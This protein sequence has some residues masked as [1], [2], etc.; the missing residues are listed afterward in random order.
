[1]T[2][3]IEDTGAP[4]AG[5]RAREDKNV[6]R[7]RR[8][9]AGFRQVPSCMYFYYIRPEARR[10][11]PYVRRYYYVRDNDVIDYG[12]LEDLVRQLAINARNPDAAAQNP[13]PDGNSLDFNVW[14]RKSYIAFVIDDPN[15]GFDEDNPIQFDY[16]DDG[17][18][19]HSFFDG[20]CRRIDL[21][22]N[23]NGGL[24]RS[25]L[26]FMNHMKE[27]AFNDL[28]RENAFMPFR[29]K[30]EPPPARGYPDSGGTNMG[31][32]IGPP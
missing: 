18:I 5:R 1:M 10:R 19:N 23:G 30:I 32:P 20:W 2:T 7:V 21:S 12:E 14:T 24:R 26:C 27:G 11:D 6:F 16:N 3:E 25:A 28:G 15:S 22:A 17:I 8:N 9:V 31:P 4:L 29:L 13:P